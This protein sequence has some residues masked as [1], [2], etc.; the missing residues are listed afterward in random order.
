[1]DKVHHRGSYGRFKIKAD[2]MPVYG[3]FSDVWQ[4]DARFYDGKIITVAVKKFRTVRIPRDADASA[5]TN[6][7]LK[8][9]TKELDIWMSLQHPNITPLIGF[10]LTDDMCMISPWYPNGNVGEYIIQHPEV[11][12]IKLVSDVACGLAYLHNLASPMVHGDMKPDNVL[13]DESGDAH[14]IDFGLSSVLEAEAPLATSFTTASLQDS[15]N[16]RWMAPELVMEEGC[17]RSPST[18]VYSFGSVALYIYTGEIPFKRIPTIQIIYALVRGQTPLGEREDY[19]ALW[20]PGLEWFRD[21]LVVCWDL[22]PEIR[23]SMTNLEE[24]IKSLGM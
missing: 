5:T 1:M 10:V 9:L 24:R 13:I 23:P 14:I 11:D 21:L 16:I 18:D 6:K 17:T 12:R 20:A 7:L 8:R 19:P 15:G 3:G 22:K 2:S 4:C